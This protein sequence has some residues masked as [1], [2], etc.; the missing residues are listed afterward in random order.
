MLETKNDLFE[1][2]YEIA[3]N[4]MSERDNFEDKKIVIANCSDLCLED[5]SNF[6]ENRYFNYDAGMHGADHMYLDGETPLR[7]SVYVD[8][9]LV[10]YVIGVVNYEQKALEIFYTEP[11]NFYNNKGLLPWLFFINQILCWV[12]VSINEI[13]NA[14]IDK[15]ALTNPLPSSIA[16]MQG[17]GY[18]F[19][20][21]Y[22]GATNAIIL[23]VSD[24]LIF[25]E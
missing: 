7:F 17:M 20:R 10:G 8:K 6:F 24:E 5:L 14:G 1:I 12:K 15:I 25:S 16:A 9:A 13:E 2:I 21:E 18:E 22:R 23:H 4:K 19:Q 3:S 11:S